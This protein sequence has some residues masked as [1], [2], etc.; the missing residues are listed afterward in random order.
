MF[1]TL[2]KTLL[3][4]SLAV[5]AAGLCSAPAAMAAEKKVVEKKAVDKKVVDKKTPSKARAHEKAL[6][7]VKADEETGPSEADDGDTLSTDYRCELGNTLTI[8][9]HADDDTHIAL[10]WK[11][12]IHRLDKVGTTTGAQR[13]QN[14]TFGLI[15]IGI[16][17]KGMLLDSKLNRQLANEC[18]NADQERGELAVKPVIRSTE[19]PSA[20][21]IEKIVPI[22]PVDKQ[23]LPAPVGK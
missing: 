17:S 13:Y 14:A 12:R 15:W 20:K 4:A 5:V 9:Q 18:K 10:R 21:V 19:M 23:A 7:V 3:A 16:P 1:L 2:K 22:V 6:K 8:F 11:K